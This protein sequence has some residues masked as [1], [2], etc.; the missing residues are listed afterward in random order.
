MPSKQKQT[1]TQRELIEKVLNIDVSDDEIASYFI[2]SQE[3]S[4][5]FQPLI[6]PNPDLIID[7]GRESAVLLNTFNKLAKARR[8]RIYK[9]RI[10]NWDGVKIVAEGDSWFQYPLILK[11]VIDQLCDLDKFKYAI[12]G[13]SEAGD[14]LSNIVREDEITAAIENENPDVFLI[15]GGGN[16]MV[17]NERMASM[18]H[19]YSHNRKV[20]NYPN[21]K[22]DEFLDEIED[23]YRNLFTRLLAKRRHLKIV[24]HGYDFAIPN[25]GKW[26]GKPLEKQKIV[27]KTLQKGIVAVMIDRFNERLNAIANDFVGSVYHVDCRSVVTDWYDELHPKN[28]SYFKVAERFDEVIKKALSD[29]LPAAPI[30]VDIDASPRGRGIASS[31]VVSQGIDSARRATPVSRLSEAD[32]ADILVSRARHVLNTDIASPKTIEER[33]QIEKDLSDHLEKIHHENDLLPIN[34]LEKGV[35]QAQSV[36]RISTIGSYGTGF[37]IANRNFIMT[38]NHVL[39]NAQE[40]VRSRAEFDYDEDNILYTVELKPEQF[41]V[42]DEELDFTIVA[43]DPDPLPD[44]ITA[45]ELLRDPATIT[46]GERANIIQHPS[47]G[48]KKVSIH[49]NKV[50]YVYDKAIQYRSDTKPGSSGSPV[51][52]NEWDLVALHHAGWFDSDGSGAATNQGIRISK[53]VDFLINGSDRE[54]TG[55]LGELLANISTIAGKFVDATNAAQATSSPKNSKSKNK[56]G[57]KSVTLNLNGGIDQITINFGE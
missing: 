29:N 39:P 38:N 8:H 57:D 25:A 10:R 27:D 7:D 43:C 42:T 35:K 15:S 18:V 3:E 1:L 50:T 46:R 56:S 41:F 17:G 52:N 4:D 23:I 13:L 22:F 32:F 33:K 11:D 45:I 5:A 6:V 31:R 55:M 34:F 12:Y 9:R 16:D 51:F 54:S 26:L 14:L 28:T 19:K 40:A 49:D 37:L 30:P 20:E 21:K 24:C 44:D 36:C 48:T 47:G 2:E 53:I